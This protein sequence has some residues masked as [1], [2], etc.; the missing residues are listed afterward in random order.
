MN[1]FYGACISQSSNVKSLMAFAF[2][3]III[4]VARAL[5]AIVPSLW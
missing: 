2:I 3:E 4:V 5:A 1:Q